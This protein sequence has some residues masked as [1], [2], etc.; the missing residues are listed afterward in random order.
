MFQRQKGSKREPGDI[1]SW[2]KILIGKSQVI[3]RKN[4]PSNK[5]L[6]SKTLTVKI[7]F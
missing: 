5:N 4:A 6:Y 2:T 1:Y 3:L 7:P